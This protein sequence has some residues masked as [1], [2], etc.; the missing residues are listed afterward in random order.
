MRARWAPFA[1]FLVGGCAYYNGVYNAKSAAHTGD[2]RF[3]QGESY[4]AGQAYLISA[5]KAETVLI[6]H[7]KTRWR[8]EA[9]YL[10]A[11]GFA[12]AGECGK[13]LRRIDEFLALPDAP[14]GQRARVVI[15]RAVC[16]LADNQP[17]SADTVLRPLLSNPDADIRGQASLWAGRVALAL[18]DPER[19]QAMF[20]AAPRNAA[21]WE[22][23]DAAFK[24]GDLATAE[25][26]LAIHAHAGQWRSEVAGRVRHLWGS[27]RRAS[28][29]NIVNQYGHSGAPSGSRVAL[30]LMMSDLAAESGDTALARL[31]AIEAQRVGITP[32]VE[33]ETRSRLLALRIRELELLTDVDAA[34]VRDSTRIR[35]TALQKRIADDLT[36]IRMFLSGPNDGGAGLFN[37]AELARDSLSAFRLARTLF[38]SI[39]RDFPEYQTAGRALLAVRS[40]FPE[41]TKVYEARIVGKWPTSYA[42]VFLQGG[43]PDSSTKKGED[44]ALSRSRL[45]VMAKWDSTLKAR[46]T[47][48]SIAAAR[49]PIRP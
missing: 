8:N 33:A 13:G 25:S 9:L 7:P 43:D 18:G 24:R 32:A 34:Y 47:A 15:A 37:A 49:G 23:M 38:L 35:G 16:L 44:G 3:Q 17:F 45:F 11:R 41:S 40:M 46:K 30:H 21:S 2:L 31:Q 22:F 14:D 12:L 39:E 28:A 19:A 4:T 29:V 42:A 27:D 20:A 6:R 26:L 36:L 5:S 1:V 48:D 10:S